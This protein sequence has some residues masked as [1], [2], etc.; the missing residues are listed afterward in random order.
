MLRRLLNAV[1]LVLGAG[2][3]CWALATISFDVRRTTA[4]GLL[5]AGGVALN[6]VGV[7]KRS[8]A[9]RPWLRVLAGLVLVAVLVALLAT[10]ASTQDTL[11]TVSPRNLPVREYLIATIRGAS[12]LVGACAYVLVSLFLLPAPAIPSL[13]EQQGGEAGQ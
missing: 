8:L 5:I 6:V 3:L 1:L 4:M 2:P 11:A 10:R 13:P 12:W 9:V 7:L